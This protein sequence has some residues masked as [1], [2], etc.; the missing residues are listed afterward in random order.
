MQGVPQLGPKDR[1]EARRFVTLCDV[2][3]DQGVRLVLSSA[4]APSALFRP[5]LQAAFSQGI[6]PVLGLAKASKA[7]QLEA[8]EA[9][10]AKKEAAAQGQAEAGGM[11]DATY[12]QG[13][14]QYDPAAETG[15]VGSDDPEVRLS[16][17]EVLMLH[18][19]GSRLTEMTRGVEC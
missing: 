14:L 1:D 15:R 7:H 10:K 11:S 2:A 9:S 8:F 12:P 3:Y 16:P 13:R 5:L 18:R 17:E 6:N 4:A 19:A